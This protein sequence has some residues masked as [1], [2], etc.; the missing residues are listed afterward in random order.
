M[1]NN[2]IINTPFGQLVITCEDNDVFAG[3]SCRLNGDILSK[4]ELSKE[5]EKIQTYV[6]SDKQDE[7]LFKE[8]H[9]ERE[10][11]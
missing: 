10:E 8:V 4:T 1:I 9:K 3:V 7:F 2:T 5:E 11:K 6:W